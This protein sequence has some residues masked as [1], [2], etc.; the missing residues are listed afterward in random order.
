ME[1]EDGTKI[2]VIGITARKLMEL[3]NHKYNNDT[4]KGLVYISSRILVN[5]QPIVYDDLLD[6]FTDEEV[7]RIGEFVTGD[8]KEEDAGKNGE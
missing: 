2:E 7:A 8:K 3:N 1:L 6:H 5:G 4:E